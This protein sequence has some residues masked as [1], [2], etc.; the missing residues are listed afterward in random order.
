MAKIRD[1]EYI[2]SFGANLRK[3]RKSKDMSMT[4]LANICGIEYRQVA[5]IELGKIN[6]TISTVKALAL[7]LNLKPRDLFEF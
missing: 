5:D 4:E 7:A 1:Q 3:I 2:K 6:T